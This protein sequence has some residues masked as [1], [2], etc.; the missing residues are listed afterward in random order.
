MTLPLW[1]QLVL[2]IEFFALLGLAAAFYGR[3]T[4]I[5]FLLGF[6]VMAP[7]AALIAWEGSGAPWRRALI[8][9]FVCVYVARMAYVLAMWFGSTGAAKLGPQS[10]ATRAALP[11]ILTN[12]C[13]W[14]YCAPFFWAAA[15]AETFGLWDGIALVLYGIGTVLHLGGDWQKRRFRQDPSNKGRLLE[16]G[17]WGLCRHPNYLGDFLVYLSFAALSAS[18]FGLIAPA[19]N[20]LQYWFDAIPKNEAM[21]AERY[22]QTWKTYADRVKMFIPY[23][24]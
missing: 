10:L 9:V 1:A 13:G 4:R 7:V 6:L 8:I 19:A 11:I 23:I 12:T 17:F 2:L 21:N 14:L 16:T 15:R 24:L 3:G 18:P 22:G 5:V 20:F